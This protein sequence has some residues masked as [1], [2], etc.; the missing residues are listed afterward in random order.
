MNGHAEPFNG[1]N[2]IDETILVNKTV[3]QTWACPHCGKR[4][5]T[6]PFADEILLENFKYLEHCPK[7]GYVHYWELRLTEE[8][9]QAVVDNLLK[10][11]IT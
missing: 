9:K 7:C 2:K 10:G 1:I 3:P 5:H 6:G 4:N 11:K 8:F